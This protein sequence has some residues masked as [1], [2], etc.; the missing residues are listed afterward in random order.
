MLGTGAARGPLAI[1]PG[2]ARRSLR[3]PAAAWAAVGATAPGDAV[4]LTGGPGEV[5][6]TADLAAALAAVGR[7]S[8]DLAGRTDVAA[9][10]AVFARC[11]AVLGPDSGPLHLAA[12]VGTPTVHLY[13][14]RRRRG[15][16]RGR[17]SGT[18]W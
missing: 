16:G 15:S 14:P 11:R 2:P 18:S 4:V 8:I 1:H 3:W 6:L 13:G 5:A 17:R 12:A 7:T 9:L 10:A